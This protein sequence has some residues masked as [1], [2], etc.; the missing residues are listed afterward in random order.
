MV[1]KKR[2]IF[3]EP[4][5]YQKYSEI[6][7]MDTPTNARKSAKTLVEEAKEAKRPSKV[8]RIIRV[9]NLAA[10]RAKVA[11]KRKNLSA[12][13]KRELR[14]IAGIYRRAMEKVQR[15]YRKKFKK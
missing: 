1:R 7:R 4:P 8:R 13:E 2:G 12:K 5:Y 14:E 9:L 15:I 3:Y 10:N 6:V 11:L